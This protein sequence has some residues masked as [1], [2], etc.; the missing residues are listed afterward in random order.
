MA[1]TVIP[2]GCMICRELPTAHIRMGWNNGHLEVGPCLCDRHA[3]EWHNMRD[4]GGQN[5][6]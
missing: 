5:A 4:K 1:T 2:I 6:R 3:E